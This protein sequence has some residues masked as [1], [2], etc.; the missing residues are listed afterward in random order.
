MK[1]DPHYFLGNIFLQVWKEV[2]SDQRS[3]RTR[4]NQS[5][6]CKVGNIVFFTLFLFH[7][8]LIFGLLYT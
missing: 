8:L 6:C 4:D 2:V 3:D 1:I 7:R 5:L